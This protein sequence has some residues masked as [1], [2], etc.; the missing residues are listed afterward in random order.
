M[1]AN[2]RVIVLKLKYQMLSKRVCIVG[3]GAAGLPSIRHALLYGFDVVCYEAQGE[4]GGLWRYKPEETDESSVMKSTVINSSKEMTAYSDFPPPAMTA[5]FMHN[6]HMC[7]Y[8]VKYAEHF[9]L[10]KYIKMYHKVLNIERND[11]YAETGRWKVTMKDLKSDKEW[12]E[13]FDGVL[14]CTG[15]H[16]LPYWPQPWPGQQN[17]QGKI[18]HAHS[19]KDYKGYDDKVVAVIGI[20][21]SG[22]DIAVE[23]SKVAK[24]V[25]LITRSGT[26]VF[27]RVADYGRPV[28][29]FLNSRF[30][31]KLRTSVPPAF[32]E[33]QMQSQLNKRFDHALYGLKPKHGI[34]SAHPTINDELPNRIAS[35]TVRVKPQIESFTENGVRFV[36][37]TEIDQVDNVIV[38]TGYSIEFPCLEKGNLVKVRENELDAY[39]FIY[40]SVLEHTTLGLIGLI[41]PYGSIMPIAEMQARVFLDVLSGATK[42]P[43]K[44][45]RAEHVRATRE[46]MQQRYAASRRHTIQVDYLPYMDDLA[47][48]IG[49]TPPI[50]HSFLPSDPK[51]A[52]ATAFA[53]FASYFYR[54]RGPHPWKE[55][56]GAIITIEDRIVQAMDAK[57]KGSCFSALRSQQVQELVTLFVFFAVLIIAIIH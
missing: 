39:Q 1:F 24:Q 41:Q 10:A 20:G 33:S 35:G 31:H 46:H 37:G 57:A 47:E 48:L 43:S 9:E 45:E 6:T 51:M 3:A 21:N 50:W 12:T 34:F 52:F 36:D 18:T 4:I 15:H 49:C 53:P 55:A 42:L 28:D 23:L 25:Y 30:Y 40:P 19:Y 54:L 22:G 17:F 44:A 11:D 56:R 32:V 2:Q 5:N 38:C 26:W 13:I 7:D 16:T 29:S 27:N 8:L 14:L